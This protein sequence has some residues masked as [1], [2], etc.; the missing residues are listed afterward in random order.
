MTAPTLL[1]LHG[2]GATSGVWSRLRAE[3]DWPGPVMAPDLAG[4]GRSPWTGSYTV[5]ALADEVVHTL[6]EDE[7]SDADAD[8]DAGVIVVGH[9][10]GGGVGLALASGAYPTPVKAVI[11]L[12]IKVMWTDDDVATMAGVAARGVRWFASRDEALARHLRQA[13][14]H[15]LLAADDPA[16]GQAVVSDNN[17]RWRVSQ[18]PATFA[19]QPLDMAGLMTQA[20]ATATSVVLGAGEH[21]AMVSQAD[22]A[23]FVDNPRIA[24]G[25][26]HN[27]HVEDPTWTARLVRE[28]ADRR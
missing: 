23:V 1:L 15:G 26:G 24:A 11:G 7:P 6:A 14:L 27:V 9:S 5:D 4:H 8:A 20:R 2:L 10:L 21:D 17:G 13:G 18:D 22:L 25:R 16:L 12:G 19:Q 28:T 3:L